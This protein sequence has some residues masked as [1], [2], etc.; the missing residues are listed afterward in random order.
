[1][2]ESDEIP[3]RITKIN[4]KEGINISHICEAKLT[5]ILEKYKPSLGLIY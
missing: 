1:M 5:Q 3:E 4:E 2:D